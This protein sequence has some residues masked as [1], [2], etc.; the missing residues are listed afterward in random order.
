MV[1]VNPVVNQPA[2]QADWRRADA[3]EQCSADT[4]I[5]RRLLAGEATRL[6]IAEGVRFIGIGHD[7]LKL[8]GDSCVYLPR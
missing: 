4:K 6:D 3:L 5:V 2:S 7:V 8:S 1:E